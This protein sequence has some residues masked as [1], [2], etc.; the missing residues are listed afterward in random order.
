[1]ISANYLREMIEL[2]GRADTHYTRGRR[3]VLLELLM[4]AEANL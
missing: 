2:L 1:M 3:D 4:I